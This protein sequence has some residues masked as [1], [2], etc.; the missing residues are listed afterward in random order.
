MTRTT[1]PVTRH[2]DQPEV[3]SDQ[4]KSRNSP[5]GGWLQQKVIF[6]ANLMKKHQAFPGSVKTPLKAERLRGDTWLH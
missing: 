5:C 6:L 2:S 1:M 4:T 3:Q